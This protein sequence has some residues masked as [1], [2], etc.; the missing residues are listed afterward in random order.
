MEWKWLFAQMDTWGDMI[1]D[2]IF[3]EIV[4]CVQFT[5]KKCA[6]PSFKVHAEKKKEK[7]CDYIFTAFLLISWE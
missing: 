1:G 4:K 7:I 6:H 3:I 5:V 2:C